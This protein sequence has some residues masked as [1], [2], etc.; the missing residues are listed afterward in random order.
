[1]NKKFNRTAVFLNRHYHYNIINVFTLTFKQLMHQTLYGTV[2]ITSRNI[3]FLTAFLEITAWPIHFEPT[4]SGLMVC[5][6]CCFCTI[7][8][9]LYKKKKKKGS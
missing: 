7:C 2:M 3:Y 6:R 5:Q 4:K 1:M 9:I 8:T